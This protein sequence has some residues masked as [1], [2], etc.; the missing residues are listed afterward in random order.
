MQIMKQ[1]IERENLPLVVSTTKILLLT[2]M[3]SNPQKILP[4]PLEFQNVL[5]KALLNLSILDSFIGGS[6]KIAMTKILPKLLR[7][8]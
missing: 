8:E 5:I 2:H 7:P 1:L 6:N 4:N 3:V